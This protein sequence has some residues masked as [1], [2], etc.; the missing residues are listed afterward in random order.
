[1]G[2]TKKVG[3]GGNEKWERRKKKGKWE[4]KVSGIIRKMGSGYKQEEQETKKEH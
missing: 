1:V 3:K 4:S 2:K